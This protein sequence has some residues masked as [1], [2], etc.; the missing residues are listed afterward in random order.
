ML[1]STLTWLS[2]T[3]KKFLSPF[4][5]RRF[6]KQLTKTLSLPAWRENKG[7]WS[8]ICQQNQQRFKSPSMP[9]HPPA[10][11]LQSCYKKAKYYKNSWCW[12]FT[13]KEWLLLPLHCN[14]YYSPCN[15]YQYVCRKKWQN[16]LFQVKRGYI[17]HFVTVQVNYFPPVQLINWRR[18]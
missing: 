1:K 9:A 13:G 4:L 14:L 12:L 6:L 11:P 2:W 8:E 18:E 7:D 16:R 5:P 10:H 3:E 17:P 15:H